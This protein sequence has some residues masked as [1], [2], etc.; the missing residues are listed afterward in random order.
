VVQRFIARIDVDRT[1][2]GQVA[3][4]LTDLPGARLTGGLAKL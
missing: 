1:L 3:S 2:G 4:A